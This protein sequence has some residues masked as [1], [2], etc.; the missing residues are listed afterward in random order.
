VVTRDGSGLEFLLRAQAFAGL[1]NLLNKS[2]FGRAKVGLKLS[3]SWALVGLKLSFSGA[4][5]SLTRA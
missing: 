2:G 5:I 4:Y 1:K 3:F